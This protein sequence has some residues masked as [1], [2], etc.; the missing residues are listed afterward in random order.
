MTVFARAGTR[1]LLE[2][3][4][5]IIDR[6]DVR[7]VYQPIVE[8][9]TLCVVAY[10]ALARGPAGSPL[11]RPDLLFEAA[12]KCGRI[13][14]LDWAWRAAGVRGA[15][16]RG[17]RSPT[18]LF[19]NVEPAA[20]NKPVPPDLKVV[21]LEAQSQLRIVLEI[22]E[23]AL[24]SHPTELL[25]SVE[26]ARE[27]GWGIAVD[28]VGADP[29]ALAM[30]P[31]LGPDVIKLD[32]ALIRDRP[33]DEMAAV[34]HAVRAECERTGGAIL[35]E[36]IESEEHLET[37]RAIGATLAQGWLFGRPRDLPEEPPQ[38]AGQV[39]IAAK[40][41]NVPV[42]RTPF[43]IIAGSRPVRLGNKRILLAMSRH[44]ETHA[45][46]LPEMPVIFA[47]FQ[48]ERFFTASTRATYA[49]LATEAAFV[50][51]FGAGIGPAPAPGVHGARLSARDPLRGEWVVVVIAPHFA[52]AFAARDLHARDVEDP[53]RLFEY[54]LTY[55]RELVT[56]V[57]LSLMARVLAL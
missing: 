3:I 10:E 11:E 22:T 29:R 8:L 5:G 51:A 2:E 21:W 39:H 35:A 30:L 40:S 14:D 28:D 52:A 4:T 56:M 25:W 13:A 16:D 49:R 32:L 57:A 24:T 37:A 17:L 20:L 31:F 45:A 23:R 41:W 33:S 47:T 19:L 34:V 15:L 43:N 6:R 27:L 26:W 55:D 48:D 36:G 44:L 9:D 18:T 46:S 1:P 54:A 7:A 38:P 42:G 53:E 12:R 50:A